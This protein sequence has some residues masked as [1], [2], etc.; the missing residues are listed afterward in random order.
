[1]S[2]FGVNNNEPE[3]LLTLN[4]VS[5]KHQIANIAVV[6]QPD[7]FKVTVDKKIT[8]PAFS[9]KTLVCPVS[10]KTAAAS[11]N[12]LKLAISD[13]GSNTILSIPANVLYVPSAKTAVSFG[14]PEAAVW[15]LTAWVQ[16][17]DWAKMKALWD[18]QGLYFL[19]Q[20]TDDSI[21]NFREVKDLQ[22]WQ[23]DGV[24]L[25]FDWNV[26]GDFNE[27]VFNADDVQLI[28][29]VKGRGD[30]KDE[31]IKG[32]DTFSGNKNFPL[33]AARMVSGRTK[34]GYWAQVEIRWSGVEA[35]GLQ[36]P[37]I[38]GFDISIRDM[39]GSFKERKRAFRCG[40]ND[41]YKSTEKFGLIVLEKQ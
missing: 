39:D 7:N 15:N 8:V 40:D 30:T 37:A 27:T 38:L 31:V 3:L 22:C 41:N 9:E 4:N 36:R 21:V 19:V 34:D 35:L 6:R 29:P 13:G 20:V 1:M 25:Y 33:N 32:P 12:L 14:K 17:S 5:S 28:M 18:D 23:S 16:L 26:A 10:R 2:R 11:G 24:E